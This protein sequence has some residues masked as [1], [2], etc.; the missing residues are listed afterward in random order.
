M[1]IGDKIVITLSAL[2]V[3]SLYFAIW[4]G[5]EEADLVQITVAGQKPE[6]VS[7]N[8]DRHLE[9]EGAQGLSKLE[10]RD[11]R[12]RFVHSPCPNQ[13]CV[14]TGWLQKAGEVAACLPNKVSLQVLGNQSFFDSIN[15]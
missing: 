3:V 5:S 10:I 11:G 4:S 14:H 7:L 8:I 9:V 2:L 12:I 6:Q 15:F 1:L 13:I